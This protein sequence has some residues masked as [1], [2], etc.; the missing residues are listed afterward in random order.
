MIKGRMAGG[1]ERTVLSMV[2][3]VDRAAGTHLLLS[4]QDRAAPDAL[5][6]G[7]EVER[8]HRCDCS[9]PMRLTLASLAI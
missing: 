8:P 5:P 1:A 3:M 7:H 9:P 6:K 2:I 4:K